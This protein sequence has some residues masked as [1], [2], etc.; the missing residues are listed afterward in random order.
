V[1]LSGFAPSV[2]NGI[3]LLTGA[4]LTVD[5]QLGLAQIQETLTVSGAA[6][7]VETTQSVLASSIRQTE[8]AQLPMLNR[9]LSA[10]MNLLP[11]AREVPITGASAHGTSSNY[12]SFGGGGGRNFNMLV[13]GLDNKEDNDG[14]TVLTYSLEGVQ[15]FR[16]LTTG[17]TAEYGRS[18][19]TVLLATKSGTNQ[20]HGTAFGCDRLLVQARERWVWQAAVQPGAVRRIDGRTDPEGPRLVLWVD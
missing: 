7:M 8:V 20:L 3:P 19:T 6:P 1:V 9:S 4:T 11:G 14:G 5:L 12:V 16:V 15:E 10:M 17:T 18:F 13:D 2:R